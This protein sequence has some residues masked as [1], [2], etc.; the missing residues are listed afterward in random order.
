VADE[1]EAD[2]QGEEAGACH[3]V[4]PVRALYQYTWVGVVLSLMDV[5]RKGANETSQTSWQ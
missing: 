1:A 2:A 5:P 4:W 3:C